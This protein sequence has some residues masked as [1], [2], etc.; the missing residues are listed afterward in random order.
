VSTIKTAVAHEV[1]PEREQ[2]AVGNPS[3]DEVLSNV[4][5]TGILLWNGDKDSATLMD[6]TKSEERHSRRPGILIFAS[7]G[8]T[9]FGEIERRALALKATNF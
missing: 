6:A 4:H 5:D 1:P 8:R 3:T 2:V 7:S 9:G